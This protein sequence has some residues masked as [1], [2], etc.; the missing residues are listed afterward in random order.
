MILV[1]A[2]NNSGNKKAWYVENVD[3]DFGYEQ[4][5]NTAIIVCVTT[6]FHIL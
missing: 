3:V 4:N 5:I 1:V 6:T 2:I